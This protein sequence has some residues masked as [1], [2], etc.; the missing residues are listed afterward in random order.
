MQLNKKMLD[1]LLEMNDDRLSSVI[2]QIA[3]EAGVD[4]NLLG[5]NPDN[6][7]EVRRALGSATDADIEG[8]S[9]VYDDY[10]RQRRGK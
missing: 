4:P 6:I 10:R 2:R 5:L 8:L 3:N 7:A 1:R 9:A